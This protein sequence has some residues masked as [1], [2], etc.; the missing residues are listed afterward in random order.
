M[1]EFSLDN[2]AGP[3]GIGEIAADSFSVSWIRFFSFMAMISVNLAILNLLPIP[4]LDGGQIVLAA[5]EGIKGSPLPLRAREIAQGVGLSLI[6]LLMGFAFW[7]DISRNWAGIV[8]FF[9]GLV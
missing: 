8:G 1:R 5:A 2:L 3:I 9:K 7:N 4:I 6:L